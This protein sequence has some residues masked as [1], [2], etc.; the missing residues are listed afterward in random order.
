MRTQLKKTLRFSKHPSTQHI[1]SYVNFISHGVIFAWSQRLFCARKSL[2]PYVKANI[3]GK[4]AVFVFL[5]KVIMLCASSYV[6]LAPSTD[7]VSHC[8][9]TIKLCVR[10]QAQNPLGILKIGRAL[11]YQ[12]DFY[13]L[14]VS[15]LIRLNLL[16]TNIVLSGKLL[17]A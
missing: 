8:Q 7:G 14:I 13:L 2:T 9:I 4:M 6:F 1:C 10:A 16:S 5:H 17:S 12:T 3:W 15:N 11:L